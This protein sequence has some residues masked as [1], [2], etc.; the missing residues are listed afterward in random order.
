MELEYDPLIAA[1]S[2]SVDALF[3]GRTRRGSTTGLT[4]RRSVVSWNTA[5][6][7]GPNRVDGAG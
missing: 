3:L 5:L 7:S 2:R 4:T 6:C 1:W